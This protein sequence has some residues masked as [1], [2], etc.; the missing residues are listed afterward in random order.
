MKNTKATQ[1]TDSQI[2][3]LAA[4]SDAAE[5]IT[6]ADDFLYGLMLAY[7]QGNLTPAIAEM[8]T[9]EFSANHAAAVREATRFAAQNPTCAR[10][11]CRSSQTAASP[12]AT[13]LETA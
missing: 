10:R 4:A 1:L 12:R 11:P 8:R 3:A 13:D 9:A 6:P 2:E 7:M 5:L